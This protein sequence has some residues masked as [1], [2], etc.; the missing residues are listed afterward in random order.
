VRRILP[1]YSWMRWATLYSLRI[2][3]EAPVRANIIAKMS[4]DF[5]ML[6]GQNKLPEYLKGAIPVGNDEDGT[7]Y[8]LK[9]KGLNP[10][11]HLND[12]MSEGIAGVV[13][14]SSSPGIKTALEQGLGQDVFLGIPFTRE[15][16][17]EYTDPVSNRIYKFDPE[18]GK[19]EEVIGKVKP[20]LFEHL[21]RNYIPQYLMME[22]LLTGGKQRYT[23]EGLDTILSD[24]FKNPKERQA[25]VKDIITMQPKERTGL[26]RELGK[27]LGINI[28]EV[29]P[30]K[31]KA[32]R[33]SI[34]RATSAIKNR[35]LPILNPQ[36]KAMIRE[37]VFK[38]VSEGKSKEEI[39]D[40]LKVWIG[41]NANALRQLAQ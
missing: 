40:D 4:R 35:E 39:K 36:F 9:T 27:A 31:E 37:R 23:A 16:V 38:S 7:V 19:T 3:T 5:Y 34:Q 6:T 28:K 12:L 8:Y 41:D 30:S 17:G 22:V 2:A 24:F 11:S 10:F 21:M 33:E 13:V 25:V 1:F 14:Q 32:R 26:L 29:E 18:T 15:R 20:A